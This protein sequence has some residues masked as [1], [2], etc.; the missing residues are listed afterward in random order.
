[1]MKTRAAL[2][3]TLL[4]PALATAT[5]LP[6]NVARLADEVRTKGWIVFPARSGQGDWDLFL[7][8]PDGSQRRPVTRTPEW[9]EAAPQFSRDGTRLLYRRLKRAVSIEGNRYG[10]QGAPVVANSDGTHPR[11]LGED[12]ELPWMSWS[13]DGQEIATL[14]LKGVAF[15]NLASRQVRRTLP[16]GGFYQQLTWS[17]DG[18]WLCGVANSFGTG[19]SVAR[20]NVAT[21]EASAVNRVDCCTPDW[22]P[23][24]ERMVFSWRPPGQKGNGG[25]GWTQLWMAD[26][27]GK[28]RQ[29]VYGEDGRHVYGGQVS[30]DGRY[31]LFTGN[32]REDGDPKNAGAPMA[33]MRI[34]DAPIIGGESKELRALHPE[35]KAGPLLILPAGWEPSWTF[36]E[37]PAEKRADGGGR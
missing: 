15:V 37:S 10:E 4:L 26:A 22:F 34:S 16:R 12:G 21:G 24:S 14:S 2:A 9:N 20:M 8:R 19:W 18:Q 25:Q 32:L 3:L 5:D 1:M 11:V 36:S 35:A 28:S 29:L 33:L 23:D 31:V 17:P 27:E 30:P 7:M 6:P 13:P